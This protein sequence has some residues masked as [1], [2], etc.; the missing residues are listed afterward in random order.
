MMWVKRVFILSLVITTVISFTG[1]GASAENVKHVETTLE[2]LFLRLNL[3]AD[4]VLP[5]ENVPLYVFST[6]YASADDSKWREMFFGDANAAVVD[7]LA[8]MSVAE[9]EEQ[10]IYD[11]AR[12]HMYTSGEVFTR[13]V[14]YDAR[15]FVEY[16]Y[17][18]YT[19][20]WDMVKVDAQAVDL[21]TTPEEAKALAQA[22]ISR[23]AQ[24]I[25]WDGFVLNQCY[26]FPIMI[27]VYEADNVDQVRTEFYMVEFGR[28]LDGKQIA[29]DTV[30][31]QNSVEA[32][33]TGDVMQLF[34]DDDGIFNVCGFC[35]SY[36]KGEAY[37][38]SISLDDAINIVEENMDYV[39][40]FSDDA[41]FDITE[42]GLYYRLVQASDISSRDVYAQTQARPAWRFASTI[43]RNMNN[44]FVIFVDA[45]TGEILP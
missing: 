14:A 22:W 4:V 6:D 30:L 28:V 38:L 2:S 23:L 24:T 12:E 15:L 13:Y 20:M 41:T 11:K 19:P 27:P 26:T 21:K 8:G 31:G 3:N 36:T 37:P 1:I 32:D 29:I 33:I 10:I 44:E 39:S 42:I 40:A 17:K 34:I 35:R 18:V 9:L 5:D 25:G 43:N 7:E 16:H 45:M